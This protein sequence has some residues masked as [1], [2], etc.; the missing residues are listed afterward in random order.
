MHKPLDGIRVIECGIFHA[1]PGGPAILSDMGAEVIKIER[2]GTG[3]P[4]R[5]LSRYKDIDFRFG[6]DRN[7]FFEGANRGKKSVTINLT[8]D[9][10]RKIAYDLVKNSD[11]FFTNF[12]PAAVKRMKM[13]YPTLSQINP[14]LIYASVTGYGPCGPDAERGG[15]DYQGQGRSGLMYSLGEPGMT[16]LLAQFGIIDQ[17]TAIMAS[18]QVVIAILVRERFGIGQEI[19]VSLLSTA[20]YLMYINN[21]VA[22]LTGKEV[23]RHEQASADP[24]RNYYQCKDGKWVIQN[25]PPGD[26]YWESMCHILGHPEL[27][28][29]PKYNSRDKRI[30]NSRDLVAIFNRAFLKKTR[31]EW[32]QLFAEKDMVMC[33]VNTTME[34]LEDPQMSEND[35]IVDFD[36]PDIGTI[37]IPGFP[38]RFSQTEINNN[39]L[40][41][42]LGEHTDTILKEI[43]GYSDEEIA[44]LRKDKII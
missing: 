14:R 33:A 27:L 3:D 44:R 26:K 5:Q 43:N 35:Y 38:I 2:P 16:P 32:L 22:L 25:Q 23:P 10:G 39:L 24:L 19:D 15:F 12:R 20:S 31:D 11:V 9:E 1:G 29:D 37:K 17:G 42:R 4:I 28:Q 18:Y 8:N 41:P 6:N 30:D 13:D 36:H 34:A 7:I 21:L 40:A